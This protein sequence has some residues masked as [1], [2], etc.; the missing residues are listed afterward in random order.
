[1][2]AGILTFHASHNY[3]SM[4]QAYALQNV[5]K[6]LGVD[7]II[8]NFRSEIQKSLIPPPISLSHPRSSMI[9]LLKEPKKTFALL[10]KYIKFENFLNHNL[11]VSKE[12]S[13]DTEVKKYIADCN[14]DTLITGSDQIWNPG[15][16]D[17]NMIYL[18]D[19]D[20]H[21]KRIAYAPSLGSTPE[22]INSKKLLEICNALNHYDYLSTREKRGSEFIHNLTG[23]IPDTVVDPTLLIDKSV[24]T[25]LL[26]K[27]DKLPDEYIFYYTPREESGTF[28]HALDISKKLKL[29]IVV[30]QD[31]LEYDGENVIHILDCGPRE[32]LTIINRANLCI[33]NS[34]HL[35]V[36]SLIFHKN[37]FMLSNCADSRMLNLLEKVNLTNRL[38]IG[39]RSV[40]FYDDIKYQE[41]DAAI[42]RLRSESE[43]YLR[44][45]LAV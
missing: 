20:F 17:F 13:T 24:Y 27:V 43:K 7:N 39:D 38:I 28:Q 9:K 40:D 18:L 23:R 31:Y 16:W 12:L 41:V 2:K 11:Y 36:F 34:F 19:F 30:T 6:N 26:T 1:M 3:G 10:R 44:N 29:P 45:A 25:P 42:L 21:G 5:L 33:G 8:I 35:L 32:F 37:F 15:C 14:F 22:T 4:L